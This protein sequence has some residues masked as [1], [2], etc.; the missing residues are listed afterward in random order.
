MLPIGAPAEAHTGKGASISC[1][2]GD[3]GL[4]LAPVEISSIPTKVRQHTVFFIK[5]L[6]PWT[7]DYRIGRYFSISQLVT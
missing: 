4:Q 7:T 6:L 1:D 2:A 3:L 5:T